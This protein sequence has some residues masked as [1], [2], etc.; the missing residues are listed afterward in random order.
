MKLYSREVL[1]LFLVVLLSASGIAWGSVRFQDDIG[2][3]LSQP[4]GSR[5]TLPSEEIYK[6]GRSGRSFAI[7]EFCEPQPSCPR[8]AVVST[9]PLSVSPYWTCD[10]TGVLSSFSGVSRDG[11]AIN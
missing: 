7:K 5:V 1:C 10:L 9:R 6:V 2:A 11:S 3:C 4:D 8:L